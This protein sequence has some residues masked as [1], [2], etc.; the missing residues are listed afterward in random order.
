MKLL[1]IITLPAVLV[2]FAHAS[3]HA[4]PHVMMYDWN[5]FTADQV[6]Q[7]VPLCI[8]EEEADKII[9]KES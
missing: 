7:F 1:S 2:G 8:T 4:T 6:R 9:N 3:V 5:C